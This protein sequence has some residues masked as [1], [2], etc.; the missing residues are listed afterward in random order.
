MFYGRARHPQCTITGRGNADGG[1]ITTSYIGACALDDPAD[2]TNDPATGSSVYRVPA[3][4]SRAPSDVAGFCRKLWGFL[5]RLTAPPQIYPV[6]FREDHFVAQHLQGVV[7]SSVSQVEAAV[8]ADIQSRAAA[9]P[10]FPESQLSTQSQTYTISFNDNGTVITLAY[11][12]Y[13]YQSSNGPTLSVGTIYR[14]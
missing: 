4:A 8:V 13:L 5:K 3:T 6:I 14:P 11:R 12:V 2:P 1:R 9:D 10:D 7:S